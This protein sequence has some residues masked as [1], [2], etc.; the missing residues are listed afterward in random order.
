MVLF[1]Y[2]TSSFHPEATVTSCV[3]IAFS[4]LLTFSSVGM[5][6]GWLH[7]NIPSERDT[8]LKILNKTKELCFK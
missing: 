5:F 6:I 7:D 8:S 1:F 2:Y 3:A 4:T